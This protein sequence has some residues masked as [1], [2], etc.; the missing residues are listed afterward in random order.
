MTNLSDLI[1][2]VEAATGP[3]RRL[4]AE[5][6]AAVRMGLPSGC[7]WAFRFPK[8]EAAP[9]QTGTVRI[10]GNWDGNGDHIAGNFCSPAYTGSVDTAMTLV[11]KRWDWLISKGDDEPAI[12]SVGPADSV[13]EFMTSAAT[14]ALALV[15]ASLRALQEK[16]IEH[17]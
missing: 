8:W 5:I 7:D 2:R 16:D 3:D 14:P 11:P 13:S 12:A 15:A 10:I 6:A 17:G 1:E 4:D 9:N